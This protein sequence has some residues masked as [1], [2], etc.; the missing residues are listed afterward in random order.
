MTA[1]NSSSGIEATRIAVFAWSTD[2][3]ASRSACWRAVISGG[4]PSNPVGTG[5]HR[6]IPLDFRRTTR[7]LALLIRYLRPK[8]PVPAK[9]ATLDLHRGL[10][11]C[12][13]SVYTRGMVTKQTA[14]RFTDEDL[15]LLDA[16]RSK[17]GVLSRT[18]VVRMA[19][20]VLAERE[21][22]KLPKRTKAAR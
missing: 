7:P 18:E 14:F 20:R 11:S 4:R 10:D 13:D 15:A 22:L 3:P 8:L 12:Q 16:L 21:G 19:I 5:A 17:V 9:C 1:S 2:M 6:V